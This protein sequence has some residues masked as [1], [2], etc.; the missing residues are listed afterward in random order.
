MTQYLVRYEDGVEEVTEASS[1]DEAKR[2]A[3]KS[4]REGDWQT[5]YT[6]WPSARIYAEGEDGDWVEVGETYITVHP[7]EPPCADDEDGYEHEWVEEGVQLN[8]G[9]VVITEVC[10]HCGTLRE[11]DTWS[12]GLRRESVSYREPDR[13]TLRY[14]RRLGRE[15]ADEAELMAEPPAKLGALARAAYMER[16]EERLA[17]AREEV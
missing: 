5:D 10:H 2:Y 13:E 9:G 11:R 15:A 16:M 12:G 8:G 1:I 3:R 14:F 4:L 17:K 7:E 6:V